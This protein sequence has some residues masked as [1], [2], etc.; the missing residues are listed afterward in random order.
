[1][2]PGHDVASG[3]SGKSGIN[4]RKRTRGDEPPGPSKR[5]PAPTI[6][7]E[8]MSVDARA[9]RIQDLQVSRGTNCFSIS[10]TDFR[11]CRLN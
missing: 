4:D 8:D 11:G 3:T 2:V 1:V 9:R 5:R 7:K 6:K 10:C